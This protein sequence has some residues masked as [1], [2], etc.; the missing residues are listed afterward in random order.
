MLSFITIK[1]CKLKIGEWC[2]MKRKSEKLSQNELAELLDISR[3]TIQ[4]LEAGKN[5]T[6]DNLLKIMN[7]FDDLNKLYAPFDDDI[8]NNNIMSLY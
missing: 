7:H 4:K 2:K 3:I 6:L 1:D 5:I 8:K